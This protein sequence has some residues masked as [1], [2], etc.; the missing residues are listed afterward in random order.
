MERAEHAPDAGSG[1]V[2]AAGLSG[3][4]RSWAQAVAGLGFVPTDAAGIER[5][6]GDLIHEL[7]QALVAAEFTAVP[8]S[9]V[10]EALVQAH[11]TDPAAIEETLRLVGIALPAAAGA[12]QDSSMPVSWPRGWSHCRPHSP[13]GTPERCATPRWP[14]RSD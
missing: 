2:S 3:L 6:L 12:D 8:A 4:A 9:Q 1:A 7:G 14:S 13:R 10:G 11:L 5:R